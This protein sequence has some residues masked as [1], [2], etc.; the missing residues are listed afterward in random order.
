MSRLDHVVVVLIAVLWWSNIR[1]GQMVEDRVLEDVEKQG[2]LHMYAP[3][4]SKLLLRI[5]KGALASQYTKQVIQNA[6][7]V[8]LGR[9]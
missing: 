1:N 4:A 7:R 6:V 9:P 8:T 2:Y 3:V 5:Q